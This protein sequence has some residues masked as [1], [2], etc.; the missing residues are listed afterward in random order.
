VINILI[1]EKVQKIFWFLW[2][3]TR[4]PYTIREVARETEVSYGST[5][6]ILKEFEELNLVYGI[7]KRRAHLYVLNFDHPL[8]FHVWSLL[9][10]L[11]REKAT[12]LVQ[13]TQ[14]VNMA[15]EG[16]IVQV[17]S[18]GRVRTVCCSDTRVKGLQTVTY[19]D[20]TRL[21]SDDREFY[22]TVWNSGIVLAGEKAFYDI[23]WEL[24]EKKVIGV[25]GK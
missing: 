6:A 4:E 21:C 18:N 1:D 24:A 19:K 8:C 23:M 11:M 7:E 2:R 16:F 15:G 10:A 5:W 17:K 13:E 9:N 14:E 22:T 12:D 25:G 20:F 3:N